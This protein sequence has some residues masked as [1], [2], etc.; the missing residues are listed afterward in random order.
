MY[1]RLGAEFAPPRDSVAFPFG[2]STFW[3]NQRDQGISWLFGLWMRVRACASSMWFACPRFR[4]K[5]GLSKLVLT[6]GLSALQGPGPCHQLWAQKGPEGSNSIE[7][8]PTAADPDTQYIRTRATHATHA[9]HA[10]TH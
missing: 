5:Q 7:A 2:P 1:Q 3:F 10:R 4:E 8:G 9:K 6:R